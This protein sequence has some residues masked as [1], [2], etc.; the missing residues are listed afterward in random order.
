[1]FTLGVFI[2]SAKHWRESI[3]EVFRVPPIYGALLGLVLNLFNVTVPELIIKPL[4]FIGLMAIPLVLLVLGYNISKVKIT[5]LPTT[6]LSSFLRVGIGLVFGFLAVNLFN[7]T[8]LLRSI[9]ILDSAMPAAAISSV[10]ATKYENEAELVSSV[11]LITTIA[12]LVIIP[13]L[14]YVLS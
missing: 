12:S 13:F 11:V 1:M 2:T 7:L 10:L 4:D 3:K 6:L 9:V 5:S 14:L 8:G